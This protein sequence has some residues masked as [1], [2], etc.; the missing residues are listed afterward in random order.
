MRDALRQSQCASCIMTRLMLRPLDR[1][2]EVSASLHKTWWRMTL[3]QALC[4]GKKIDGKHRQRAGSLE[5]GEPSQIEEDVV[6]DQELLMKPGV[7]HREEPVDRTVYD[8]ATYDE[9]VGCSPQNLRVIGCAHG[10]FG[11]GARAL[12]PGRFDVDGCNQHG[13]MLAIQ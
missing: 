12:K 13:S 9:M 4:E 7:Q 5:R 8:F 6:V 11:H 1:N 2:A 10:E 3:H